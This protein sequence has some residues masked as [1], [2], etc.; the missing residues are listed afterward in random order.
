MEENTKILYKN[1][2]RYSLWFAVAGIICY[3]TLFPDGIYY[4]FFCGV[5]AVASAM[6][7]KKYVKSSGSTVG[8]VLGIIDT[9]MAV[10]AFYGIY[11]IYS[12][13]SDPVLGPRVTEFISDTLSQNGI[14]LEMFAQ[15]MGQ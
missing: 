5:M 2:G 9:I 6:V 11:L 4:G 1:I 7:S 8:L 10:I 3:L 13:I 12:T 15:M 14:S